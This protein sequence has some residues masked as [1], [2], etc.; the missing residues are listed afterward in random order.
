MSYIVFMLLLFAD[1]ST[2]L[3]ESTA[4]SLS[5]CDE[6]ALE[7]MIEMNAESGEVMCVEL[8]GWEI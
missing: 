4:P 6:L 1:G 2:L 8:E 5:A 7:T 3:A